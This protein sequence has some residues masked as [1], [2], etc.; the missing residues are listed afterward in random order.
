MTFHVI[1]MYL[2]CVLFFAKRSK[3]EILKA[4]LESAAALA[5]RFWLCPELVSLIWYVEIDM[6]LQHL[7]FKVSMLLA[8]IRSSKKYSSLSPQDMVSDRPD[9]SHLPA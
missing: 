3:K 8:S 7:R 6:T 2:T 1:A 9:R 5:R 4:A